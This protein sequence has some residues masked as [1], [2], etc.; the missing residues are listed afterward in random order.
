[1]TDMSPIAELP[2][3]EPH[4]GQDLARSG[5]AFVKAARMRGVLTAFG[6]LADWPAFA[7]SWDDLAV[8]TYMADGG[9]YR[10]R[11]HAVFA[12]TCEGAIVRA[13]HQPHYQATDYNRL[14]GG[15]ERWFE[16]VE[17]GIGTGASL[18][19]IVGFCRD[20]FGALAPAI[21]AWHIEVHQFRIEART[22]ET[23][24][25][26]PEGMHRDGVDYV[27]V[28]LV[29]RSNIDSGTTTITDLAQSPLGSFTLTEPFDAALV[30]DA[31]AY[32]G[33]TP[34]VPVDPQAPAFRDV[35]VVTFRRQPA[36]DKLSP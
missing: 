25:P 29:K 1:M 24:K 30:D 3:A 12:T 23:G 35:L 2:L 27:L 28:L 19:T 26:T 10:K 18:L 6:S 14:N 36:S 33:V 16:P 34:V 31:R 17:A 8:D 20:L 21:R 15:V 9:R 22:G 11:R 5:F 7:A 4:L 32:H 13:A